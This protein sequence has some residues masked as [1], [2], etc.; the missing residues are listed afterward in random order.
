MKIF[1]LTEAGKK[2]GLGHITRCI[3]LYD[4]FVQKGEKPCFIINSG[5]DIKDVLGKR[6]SNIYDWAKKTKKTFDLLND[7]D[8]AI[9]DSY[10]APSA[11]YEKLSSLVRL[12]VYLDD[13]GRIDYP[14]G[15]V[16]NGGFWAREIKYSRKT[17]QGYLLGPDYALLRNVF[18]SVPKK[19]INKNPKNVLLTFGGADPQNITVKLLKELDRKYPELIKTVVVGKYNACLKSIEKVISEKDRLVCNADANEMKKIMAKADV[20]V[21]AAGQTLYELAR[22]GVP[23]LAVLTADNQ[24]YNAKAWQ[25]LGGISCTKIDQGKDPVR[26]I[27]ER[28]EKLISYNI[29]ES[30]YKTFQVDITGEG[31]GN[32]VDVLIQRSKNMLDRPGPGHDNI[33]VAIRAVD[34][35]DCRDMWTWR[36]R[37]EARKWSFSKEVIGFEDHKK[38]FERK[39]KDNKV[40]MYIAENFSGGKIGHIR[41]DEIFSEAM[42]SI[43]LNPQYYGRGFGS[44]VIKKATE[45]FLKGNCRTNEIVAEIN[46]DNIASKKAFG[47]AGYKFSKSIL[48]KGAHTDIFKFKRNYV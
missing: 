15:I 45:T 27:L 20:A 24:K 48:R 18:R 8:I 39:L 17:G 11:F 13:Y 1:I 38:W 21:S 35:K 30:F 2:Y 16:V 14:K 46:S 44:K 12:S 5:K 40:R 23:A 7:A 33:F 32:I 31:A 9:I 47:R 19:R 10:T 4:A 26:M 36:N 41:F 34:Q 22:M 3:A 25:A 43:H 29:R 6:K 42:V 28:F 37:P